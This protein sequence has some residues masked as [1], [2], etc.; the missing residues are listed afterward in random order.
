MIRHAGFQR[1][2]YRIIYRNYLIFF[3][4]MIFALLLLVSCSGTQVQKNPPKGIYHIVKKGETAYGIARAYSINLQELAKINNIL[5]VSSIKEDSVIFIPHA[6]KVIDD[7]IVRTGKNGT[8]EKREA[9]RKEAPPPEQIKVSRPAENHPPPT[10][11]TKAAD[12]PQTMVEKLHREQA[13]S[14]PSGIPPTATEKKGPEL[15]EKQPPA[16]KKK[17]ITPGNGKFIWPVKGTVKTHFGLQP[18]K[19]YYNWIKIVCPEGTKIKSAAGGTV[20]FSANL[21]EFSETI[22]IRHANNLAT[23]YTHLKKRYVQADETV[24]KGSAIALAGEK[25]NM[26]DV[27]INFEIRYKSKPQNPLLYLP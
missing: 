25:D 2:R 18:N 5:D 13:P 12:K 15:K 26:G 3:P 23:V 21:K 22:I 20:I 8:D 6:D 1:G 7:I 19:T 16:K 10:K 4:L 11:V 9:K 17:E 14:K 27:F 24:K